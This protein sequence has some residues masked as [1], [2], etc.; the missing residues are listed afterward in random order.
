MNDTVDGLDVSNVDGA[1]K[2]KQGKTKEPTQADLIVSFVRQRAEVFLGDDDH[3]YVALRA[4]DDDAAPLRTMR[5]GS[6]LFRQSASYLHYQAT[7]RAPTEQS[8][9]SAV[10]TLAGIARH[11]G[12]R[13][14]V[15]LRVGGDDQRV[16][17]DLGDESWRVVEIDAEGW[18]IVMDPP[19]KFRRSPALLPLPKPEGGGSL[20][21]LKQLVRTDAES[22]ILLLLF[23]VGAFRVGRPFRHLFLT[24]IQGASKSMMARLVRRLVDPSRAGLRRE[25][26]DA[27]DLAIAA[28]N[29][30]MPAF[31]NVSSIPPW[32]SDALCVLSTG[33]AFA[34]RTL[35]ENAEETIFEARRPVILTSITDVISR[36]DLLERALLISLEPLQKVSRRTEARLE[37]AFADAHPKI[38]GAVFDAVSA[39]IKNLPTTPEV[40]EFRMADAATWAVAAGPA[41]GLTR[42]EIIRAL[43]A[44][45]SS[46]IETAI[47]ASPI[48]GPLVRFLRKQRDGRWCGTAKELLDGI[49]G[50]L[51]PSEKSEGIRQLSEWP[52]RPRGMTAALRRISPALPHVGIRYLGHN[53]H[54]R[55]HILEL[56]AADGANGTTAEEGAAGHRKPPDREPLP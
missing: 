39:A 6:K 48:V 27:R 17:V 25:P 41:L 12:A 34:T 26:K 33:G 47:E 15:F 44:N 55:T 3:E 20:S 21:A 40:I 50:S 5:L 24:G 29:S 7:G 4:G 32:L 54:R 49:N 22:W 51:S 14:N 42:E 53:K 30:Y 16:F 9:R 38:L 56:I 23:L 28:D 45:E 35:Y 18:R 43:Q 1:G 8:L 52:R 13:H 10:T 2:E 19:I 31:D 46:A 11:E 36:P 37:A